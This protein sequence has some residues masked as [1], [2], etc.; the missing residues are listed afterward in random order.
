MLIH[1]MSSLLKNLLADLLGVFSEYFKDTNHYLTK[2]T[3]KRQ[4]R[5]GLLSETDVSRSDL[6]VLTYLSVTLLIE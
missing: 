2:N 3:P 1:N 6:C 5:T 4:R